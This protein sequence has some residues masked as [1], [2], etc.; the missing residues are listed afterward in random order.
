VTNHVY[1]QLELVGSSSVGIEDAVTNALAKASKSVRNIHWF[2]IMETRGTVENAK[3]AYW[4][5]AMKVGFTIE[6]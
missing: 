5:V 6:D 3:V 2:E 1:K 4:Q